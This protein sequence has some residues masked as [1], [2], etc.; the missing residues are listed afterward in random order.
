MRE[1][2]KRLEAEKT[3][4]EESATTLKRHLLD[5]ESERAVC[6][7]SIAEHEKQKVACLQ[8]G[9][10]IHKTQSFIMTQ[11]D[12]EK[13]RESASQFAQYV[14]NM[15]VEA[16]ALID[17]DV[18]HEIRQRTHELIRGILNTQDPDL[19]DL[20]LPVSQLVGYEQEIQW[21]SWK[22]LLCIILLSLFV[23]AESCAAS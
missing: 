3:M 2:E 13:L 22:V 10:E 6:K 19:S 18:I 16:E 14:G 23:M 11:A 9:R 15:N 20:L 12:Y 21:L 1:E 17:I 8:L 4:V 5:L 7:S